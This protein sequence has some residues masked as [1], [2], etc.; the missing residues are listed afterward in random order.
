MS[1]EITMD[2]LDRKTAW[3]EQNA[4]W[5]R[6]SAIQR[7][8]DFYFEKT[9]TSVDE[10]WPDAFTLQELADTLGEESVRYRIY[11]SQDNLTCRLFVFRPHCT[12]AEQKT[13][14]DLGFV[15]AQDGDTDNIPCQL[16]VTYLGKKYL[17]PLLVAKEL[18]D[19]RVV[20]LANYEYWVQGY[21]FCY[22]ETRRFHFLIT[23]KEFTKL[24]QLK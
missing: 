22:N 5:G 4:F 12:W 19:D 2:M 9:R 6:G 17:H 16:T 23:K 24:E 14:L 21:V 15:L 18:V 10:A 7:M 8:K 3:C 20:N 13:M 11:Y 1:N